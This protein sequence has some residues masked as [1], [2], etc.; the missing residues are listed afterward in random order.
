MRLNTKTKSGKKIIDINIPIEN[1]HE[2]HRPK[3]SEVD[4]LVCNNKKLL[5]NTKWEPQ[6]D[7]GEGL[8]A[9]IDWFKKNSHLYKAG[10]YNV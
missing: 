2:R 7:L 9:T 4:R 10:L 6:Y 1:D 8:L 5:N 3:N